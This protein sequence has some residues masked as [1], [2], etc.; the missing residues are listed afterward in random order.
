MIRGLAPAVDRRRPGAGSGLRGGCD[1]GSPEAALARAA[2]LPQ[3]GQVAA[4]F[5]ALAVSFSRIRAD[6]PERSRR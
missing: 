3:A 2:L 4:T 6:L 5:G 1:K